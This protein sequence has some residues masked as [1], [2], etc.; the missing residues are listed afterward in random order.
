[1]KSK[2]KHNSL[3]KRSKPNRIEYIVFGNVQ[4]ARELV[5]KYG[6]VPPKNIIAL[7]GAVKQLAKK[8]GK[9]FIEEL[10]KIH[11]EKEMI[12]KANGHSA[13]DQYCGGCQSSFF[14]EEKFSERLQEMSGKEL[15]QYYDELLKRS[16]DDPANDTLRTQLNILWDAIKQLEKPVEE[17]QEKK[18]RKSAHNSTQRIGLGRCSSHYRDH[19]RKC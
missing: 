12:L 19:Y 6:Y 10:L 11:P 7:A 16:N 4:G 18:K 13:Y 8:K 15:E 9:D 3:P 2:N 5:H 14:D 17:E 1:M